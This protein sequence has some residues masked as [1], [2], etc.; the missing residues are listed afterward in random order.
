M[1]GENDIKHDVVPQSRNLDI[2]EMLAVELTPE[3]ERK[4]LRKLDFILIPLMGCAYFLQFLDKLALSQSTL[5]N[6]RQDLNMHGS[7]YSWASAIFYFGY[8]FWSW[9]SSYVIVRLPIGKYLSVSVFLWGGILMCHAAC[10]NFAGLMVARFFLGVGEAAIA[11][12]FTLLTGMFYK[13][14]EQPL[15]QSAWFFGNCIAVLVGG[16]IAYGIGSISTGAIEHW[17][18]LFLILGAITSTYGIVLFLLLPDSPAKAVFLKPSERTIT[19]KRTLQNKTGVMDNGVF[20]WSQV[21]EASI[22]PQVWLLVLNSFASNLCNGGITSF[23]SIITAGFG[24]TDLKALLMQMPQGAAQIVFLLITSLAATF[25]PSCRILG[26]ILNTIVSVVGM[27]LI[28]KLNPA[29]QVGRMV[30]LTLGVVY[31]IN[32]PISLS[33]VTSNVAGFSKKSV[34]SAL[35]FIAYCVGNIVGPQFFLASE[36]PSYPTGITAAMSG[37]VLSIFFLL[38]L[39]VYYTWENRRRDKLYGSPADMTVGAELREELSNK[40][41]RQIESFRYLL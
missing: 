21:R 22:D 37:L 3:E 4:V 36:E 15:R 28:W 2:G 1:I 6:L 34:T 16:L 23:T 19:I 13:R 32:L 39:Y 9:P 14:E 12:G 33:I 18:L 40:T 41:D 5:F 17:K 24:F 8:F 7:E 31:A 27:L 11:P 38:C 25:V 10:T 20:K 35:L 30:G 26:M 29:E